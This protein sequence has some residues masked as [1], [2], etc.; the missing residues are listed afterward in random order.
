MGE[1]VPAIP[2]PNDVTVPDPGTPPVTPAADGP[3]S[4]AQILKNTAVMS[5]GTS[6]SRVTG[7]VRLA[8]M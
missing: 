4:Q 6:L 5:V 2:A 8:A 3:D 1:E 7:F